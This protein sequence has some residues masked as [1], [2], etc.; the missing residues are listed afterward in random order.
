M[1]PRFNP[2]GEVAGLVATN[3]ASGKHGHCFSLKCSCD[4]HKE[5]SVSKMLA[6]SERIS[7]L[8]ARLSR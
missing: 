8:N 5:S 6:K 1:K 4:C 7:Q 2:K 3:C